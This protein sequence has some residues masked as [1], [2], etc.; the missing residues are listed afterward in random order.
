MKS[1]FHI[2]CFLFLAATVQGLNLAGLRRSLDSSSRRL[3]SLNSR[4]L[5]SANHTAVPVGHAHR[6]SDEDSN[7]DLN[8]EATHLSQH[9][10]QKHYPTLVTPGTYFGRGVIYD[11]NHDTLVFT[12]VT[13]AD[14]VIKVFY[15]STCGCAVTQTWLRTVNRV[16]GSVSPFGCSN[17]TG[18]S[19]GV[20]LEGGKT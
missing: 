11:V 6:E 14:A 13:Y 2:L 18:V 12:P 1:V 10:W 8:C 7:L 20:L 5:L 16:N 19:A 17:T 4:G 15:D 9:F 3:L